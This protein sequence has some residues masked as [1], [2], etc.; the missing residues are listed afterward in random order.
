M[1]DTAQVVLERPDLRQVNVKIKGTAPLICHRWSEKAK[2]QMLAKQL[3]Q[4][5]KGREA[6]DPEADF[7]ASLYLMEL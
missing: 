7:T 5:S 6:K 1:S 2:Q 4:A 3:K